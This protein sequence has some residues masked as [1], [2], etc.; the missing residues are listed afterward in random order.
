M[1]WDD[2]EFLLLISI[3]FF[4]PSSVEEEDQLQ[5]LHTS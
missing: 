2:L 1:Y 3:L 5:N 4:V